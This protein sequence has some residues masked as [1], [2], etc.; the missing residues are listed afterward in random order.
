VS[1]NGD[2]LATVYLYLIEAL[3]RG[4]EQGEYSKESYALIRSN[5]K[6]R[7]ETILSD[8]PQARSR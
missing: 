2:D 4:L 5:L 7:L 8:Q 3:D 1:S 6:R